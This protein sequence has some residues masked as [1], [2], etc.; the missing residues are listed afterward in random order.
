MFVIPFPIITLV[1]LLQL[2]KAPSP[3]SVTLFGM[4]TLVMPEP[5]KAP[6]NI[7]KPVEFVPM[8]ITLFGMVMFLR[9][10][11]PSKAPTPM[12]V[13]LVGM[14]TLLRLVQW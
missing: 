2:A 13:T 11:Q 7:P 9:L 1:R 10:V 4:V 5:A 12:L 14:V 6:P 8:L 3:M